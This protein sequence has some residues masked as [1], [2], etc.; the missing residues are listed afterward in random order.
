MFDRRSL[1]LA[2]AASVAFGSASEAQRFDP[3]G[4]FDDGSRGRAPQSDRDFDDR[5]FGPRGFDRDEDSDQGGRLSHDQLRAM[6]ARQYSVREMR[7]SGECGQEFWALIITSEGR[8][9]W[10]VLDVRD[11]RFLRSQSYAPSCR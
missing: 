10:I 11:G 4:S 7:T 1:L 3:R 2:I 9:Q 8:A 5:G 6:V